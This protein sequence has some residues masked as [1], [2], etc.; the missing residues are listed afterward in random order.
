MTA[1][2]DVVVLVYGNGRLASS[3][4]DSRRPDRA[5]PR[6]RGERRQPGRQRRPGCATLSRRPAEEATT[7]ARSGP[8]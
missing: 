7:T 8:A 3:Y 4:L 2:I 5:A 1:A 6:D